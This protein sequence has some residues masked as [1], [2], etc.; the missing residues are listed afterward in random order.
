MSSFTSAAS[1]KRNCLIFSPDQDK[2]ISAHGPFIESYDVSSWERR[3]NQ[4]TEQPVRVKMRHN[5]PILTILPLGTTGHVIAISK[6]YQDNPDEDYKV[7]A[8]LV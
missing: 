2:V 8:T 6:I 7:Y 1:L 4:P 5:A 3:K